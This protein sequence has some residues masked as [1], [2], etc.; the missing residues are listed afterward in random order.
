MCSRWNL[1][2][3]RESV[4]SLC[5]CRRRFKFV[6]NAV[7]LF[8][9]VTSFFVELGVHVFERCLRCPVH[10]FRIQNAGLVDVY[11]ILLIASDV[12]RSDCP[13]HQFG[14]S[15]FICIVWFK[16]FS[17]TASGFLQQTLTSSFWRPGFCRRAYRER[18]YI[19]LA[20][21]SIDSPF[22]SHE[23]L[24]R[25]KA[26]SQYVGRCIAWLAWWYCRRWV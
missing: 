25:Q 14:V 18:S 10:R 20:L 3:E 17:F 19:V 15:R 5:L 21:S 2:C 7:F 16:L 8:F 9:D 12:H 4:S 6:F 13:W 24:C 26:A 1:V 22:F 11:C 23:K